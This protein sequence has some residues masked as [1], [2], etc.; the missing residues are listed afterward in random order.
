MSLKSPLAVPVLLVSVVSSPVLAQ[1]TTEAHVQYG[2]LANPRFAGGGSSRNLTLTFQHT[3]QSRFGDLFF[4]ADIINA[5]DGL[6]DIYGEMYVNFSL[7]KISKQSLSFGPI[8]DIGVIAGFNWVADANVRK[9][10]PGVRLSWEI[11]GFL[12]LNTDITAYL[13]SSGGVSSGGAPSES[14]SFMADVNWVY[15]FNIGKLVL[16]VEGHV[17]YIGGRTN[18]FEDDVSWWILGQPQLRL[19]LGKLMS[20]QPNEFFV[21]TEYQFWVNKLGDQA[22]D[23]SA[24]QVLAESLYNKLGGFSM[25]RKVVSAGC[26]AEFSTLR[27]PLRPDRQPAALHARSRGPVCY[28]PTA[29]FVNAPP[30]NRSELGPS[31]ANTLPSAST[32]T[33]SPAAPW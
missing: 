29:Y 32:A 9:Y 18:E 20:G 11:P 16:S 12:F 8:R 23:E 3:S 13:D 17:E 31:A 33:P 19:D 10:L 6:F 5:Q 24:F 26:S 21:G 2:N 22:T 4:F 14:S 30:A 28:R 7:G 25:L 1:G 15:P 27:R